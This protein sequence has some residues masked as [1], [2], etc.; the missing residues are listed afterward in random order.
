MKLKPPHL[1]SLF[2]VVF[3]IS[4]FQTSIA[5]DSL[6][7]KMPMYYKLDSTTDSISAIGER[8]ASVHPDS[9]KIFV[10]NS[11]PIYGYIY[12]ALIVGAVFSVA[13]SSLGK[14]KEIDFKRWNLENR[15]KFK[16]NKK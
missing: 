2:L 16:N 4:L 1:K 13:F 9:I 12:I 8:P 15:E 5:Q 14:K 10:D 6:S 3:V 11:F 7:T